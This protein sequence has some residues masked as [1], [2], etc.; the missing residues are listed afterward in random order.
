MFVVAVRAAEGT[1][2]LRH[3][4]GGVRRGPRDG[5]ADPRARRFRHNGGRV[6]PP[7]AGHARPRRGAYGGHPRCLEWYDGWYGPNERPLRHR[8]E[9]PFRAQVSGRGDWIRTSDLLNPIQVRYRTAL[10]PGG[11]GASV[12]QTRARAHTT[13]EV[14]IRPRAGS[15]G[16]VRRSRPLREDARLVVAENLVGDALARLDAT[17]EVTL[18]ILGGVLATEV[19]LAASL[20]LHT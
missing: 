7:H 3:P 9:G 11:S 20:L 6:R 17:V 19:D 13:R 15:Y 5:F 12:R 18:G 8:R 14:P 16:R 2:G 4:D 10:R 1:R